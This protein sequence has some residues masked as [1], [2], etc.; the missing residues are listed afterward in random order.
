MQKKTSKR[1][2]KSK[3][4]DKFGFGRLDQETVNFIDA[5]V[6]ELGSKEAVALH[7]KANDTVSE[8]ARMLAGVYFGGEE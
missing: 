2:S 7:Y 5:K 4:V 3:T 6:R 1:K 8:F